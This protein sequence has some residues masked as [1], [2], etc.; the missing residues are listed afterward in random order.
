LNATFSRL[1]LVSFLFAAACAHDTARSKAAVKPPSH[2]LVWHR[3]PGGFSVLLPPVV[4]REDR[5]TALANREVD[6]HFIKASPPGT[7]ESYLVSLAEVPPDVLL[8]SNPADILQGVQQATVR[9]LGAD[10]ID[11]KEIVV[12]EMPGREFAARKPGKGN[13]LARVLVGSDG[14][15]TLLGTFRFGPPPD[16]ILRFLDSFSTGG[17][18]ASATL[19]PDDGRVQAKPQSSPAGAPSR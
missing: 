7:A 3:V 4:Q 16:V 12:D 14:V 2:A 5:T 11:S 8:A 9:G 19:A 13:I 17:D 15:Y 10:L 1:C 18:M 6:V